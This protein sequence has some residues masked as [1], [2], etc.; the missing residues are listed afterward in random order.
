[1]LFIFRPIYFQARRFERF[2]YSTPVPCP[3]LPPLHLAVTNIC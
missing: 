1:V 3:T 2:S